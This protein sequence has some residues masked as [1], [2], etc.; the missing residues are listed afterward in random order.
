[1]PEPYKPVP[2]VAPE[3]ARRTA[4]IPSIHEEYPHV[5]FTRAGAEALGEVGRATG[6]LGSSMRTLGESI[7]TLG[8]AYDNVGNEM[9]QRAMG[10]VELEQ[11]KKVNDATIGYEMGQMD[12]DEKFRLKEGTAADS[13][14][15]KAHLTESENA[16]QAIKNTLSPYSQAKFDQATTRAF[17]QSAR[18]ASTH[19]ATETRKATAGS[20][21]ALID[22]TTAQMAKTTEDVDFKAGQQRVYDLVGQLQ[23]LHGW[24]NEETSLFYK[25]QIEDALASRIKDLSLKDPGRAMQMLEENKEG[26]ANLKLWDQTYEHVKRERDWSGSRHIG[27]QVRSEMPDAPLADWEKRAAELA[28]RDAPGDDR[29]K[30]LAIGEARNRFAL[31][32]QEEIDQTQKDHKVLTDA[33]M[34]KPGQ[35][36][37]TWD[38]FL[39]LP[40]VRDALDRHGNTIEDHLRR[41]VLDNPDRD[42]TIAANHDEIFRNIRGNLMYDHKEETVAMI[43]ANPSYIRSLPI[44]TREQDELYNIYQAERAREGKSEAQ[45]RVDHGYNVLKGAYLVPKQFITNASTNKDKIATFKSILGE[46]AEREIADKK[47]ALTDAEWKELGKRALH[48]TQYPGWFGTT[49]HKPYW[50]TFR[51]SDE[52]KA[53]VKS[54]RAKYPNKSDEELYSEFVKSKVE[55]DLRALSAVPAKPVPVK[56]VKTQPVTP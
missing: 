11:E 22:T 50:Q 13:E 49:A 5:Q 17:I 20:I 21:Q 15:L 54:E 24:T 29:Y 2:T 30:K 37:K 12:R 56:P 46:Y 35:R 14:A 40:G 41:I 55:K 6:V 23:H 45:A 47:R 3:E 9:Y 18:L 27:D 25:K 10:L 4:A 44:T 31:A 53:Y 36:P 52:H 51:G 32:K 38:E 8:K 43:A 33:A 19:A 28:E 1:M 39:L 26:F 34:G 42:R 7:G 48:E 16:R